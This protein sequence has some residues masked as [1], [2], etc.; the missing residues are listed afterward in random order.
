MVKDC[1]AKPRSARLTITSRRDARGQLSQRQVEVGRPLTLPMPSC[2]LPGES[3]L[4]SWMRGGE[5][6]ALGRP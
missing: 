2:S 1:F 6:D 5:E 3:A 4:R